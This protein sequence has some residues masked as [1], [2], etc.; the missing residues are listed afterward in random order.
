MYGMRR[1]FRERKGSDGSLIIPETVEDAIADLA[2]VF[3]WT[4]ND[5][6]DMTLAEVMNWRERARQRSESDE[7]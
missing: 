5:C 1:F 4:F 6:A 3:H 2:I 7:K